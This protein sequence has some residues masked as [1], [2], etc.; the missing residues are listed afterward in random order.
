MVLWIQC[1]WQ[2]M[3]SRKCIMDAVCQNQLHLCSSGTH[4]CRGPLLE[5]M[6]PARSN[7]PVTSALLQEYTPL[8]KPS[9]EDLVPRRV[10]V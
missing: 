1:W 8:A 10:A 9:V 3:P 7:L 6:K 4:C 5:C 2:D